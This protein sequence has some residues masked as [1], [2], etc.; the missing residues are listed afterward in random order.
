MPTRDKRKWLAPANDLVR[1]CLRVH[2]RLYAAAAFLIILGN[3]FAADTVWFVWPILAWGF[4]VVLHGIYV[5]SI[6]VD[7]RW[8]QQRARRVAANAYDASHIEDIGKRYRDR[9]PE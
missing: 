1:R 6:S 2:L 7:G 8:A 9:T 4:F 5:K 3:I